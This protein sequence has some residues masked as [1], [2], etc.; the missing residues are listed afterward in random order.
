M[1]VQMKKSFSDH[2]NK[3][4][5]CAEKDRDP[6]NILIADKIKVKDFIISHLGKNTGLFDHILWTGY[7]VNE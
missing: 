5:Y 2:M 7:D 4:L 1:E 3:Y 6:V